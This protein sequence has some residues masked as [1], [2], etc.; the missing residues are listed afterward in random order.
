M[1]EVR[2]FD[3]D[4]HLLDQESLT[5]H[6]ITLASG[7]KSIVGHVN[8]K[9]LNLAY[10]EERFARF[11]H[12]CKLVYSDGFGPLMAARMQG[13]DAQKKHRNSCP[14]FL[15]ELLRKIVK[16]RKKIFFLGNEQA[17]IE[18]LR[19]TLKERHPDLMYDAHH[20]FFEK[21]GA[22]N[23]AVIDIINNFKPD[24]LYVG[25][26]MP[27]QE[28]WIEENMD[29]VDAHV[30]L[31]EGACLDFYTDSVYR[32]PEWLTDNGLEWAA[33]LVTDPGRLW[34]RYL[35]GNPLFLFRVLKSRITK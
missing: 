25:F 2:L 7:S 26:G 34:K 5:D 29:Q 17:V 11:Y 13:Y 28:Y 33:R 21:S 24:I 14:D 3:I 22:E 20:G 16:H 6:I 8:I 27:M 18:K 4:I 35:I 10:E 12:R 15:D 30:F 23:R 19:T 1:T 31:P 32:A 9:G